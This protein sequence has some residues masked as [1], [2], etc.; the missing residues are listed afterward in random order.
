MENFRGSVKFGFFPHY[1]TSIQLT[2]IKHLLYSKY[3]A[4]YSSADKGK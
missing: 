4:R 2:F 1:K 3:S